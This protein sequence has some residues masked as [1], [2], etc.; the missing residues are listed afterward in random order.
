MGSPTA[1]LGRVVVRTFSYAHRANGVL[2]TMIPD[3]LVRFFGGSFDVAHSVLGGIY[4]RSDTAKI[5]F[6][7]LRELG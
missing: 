4:S 1:V 7:I 5:P 6:D 3:D 2:L